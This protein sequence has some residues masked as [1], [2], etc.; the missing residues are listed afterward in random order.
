MSFTVTLLPVSARGRGVGQQRHLAG[1]L[2]RYGDVPLVLAAVAGDPAGPDL[3]AV[4]DVLPQQGGVLVVDVL[5]VLALAE[6]ADLLLGFANGWLCH[7]DDSWGKVTRERS[8]RGLVG[9]SAGS[10]RWRGA[11]RVVRWRGRSPTGA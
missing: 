11:P 8:E 6:D 7:G 2:H 1:V 3:A 9:V 4:G 5:R 10:G